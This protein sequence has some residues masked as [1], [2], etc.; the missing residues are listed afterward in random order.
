MIIRVVHIDT[1][2]ART[3]TKMEAEADGPATTTRAMDEVM[4]GLE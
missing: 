1:T 4:K 3:V 2:H